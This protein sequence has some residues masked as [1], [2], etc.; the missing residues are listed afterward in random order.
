MAKRHLHHASTV[1]VLLVACTP[2]D[3]GPSPI[4]AENELMA[5]SL[6]AAWERGDAEAI[7][8]AFWPDATYDDFSNSVQHRG[9]GEV[10]AYF[11]ETHEWASDVVVN[12]TAVHPSP[13][14]A[15]AEWVFS[16][17]QTAAVTGMLDVGTGREV[18]LNGVTVLEILDGR[19]TR[20]ADYVDTLPLVL[21]LGGR[22]E[23][24]GGA[25][26]EMPGG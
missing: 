5:R 12:V 23:M 26:L 20:G 2:T 16:A 22:V 19:I 4:L 21:Q 1:A 8:D 14:G 3:S 18:I 7:G 13:T 6:L 9:V 17:V 24:P 10:A 11:A 15:V 25:V